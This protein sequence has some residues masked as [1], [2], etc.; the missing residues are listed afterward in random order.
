MA[1]NNA[2]GRTFLLFNLM[3]K[4]AKARKN[5]FTLCSSAFHP[6]TNLMELKGSGQQHHKVILC[7]TFQIIDLR[8]HS[9]AVLTQT[10][11]K[12]LPSSRNW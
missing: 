10:S 2:V 1:F 12:I 9:F 6:G 11:R 4:F 8:K 3:L 5:F 7:F